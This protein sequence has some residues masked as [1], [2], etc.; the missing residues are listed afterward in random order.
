ML[1]GSFLLSGLAVSLLSAFFVLSDGFFVPCLPSD[2]TVS[3]PAT[4]S[5]APIPP[6]V[7]DCP[8]VASSIQIGVPALSAGRWKYATISLNMARSLPSVFALLMFPLPMFSSYAGHTEPAKLSINAL[9]LSGAM[10]FCMARSAITNTMG[11]FDFFKN[12]CTS[13]KASVRY[14]VIHRTTVLLSSP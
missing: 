3:L 14:S 7:V 13:G 10:S 5:F 11:T 6:D 1:S 12:L 9:N 4:F 2:L 8:F